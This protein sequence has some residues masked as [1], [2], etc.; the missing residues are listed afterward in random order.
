[1]RTL[2]AILSFS[3]LLFF[4]SLAVASTVVINELM[5]NPA[6]SDTNEW[7]EL[8]SQDTNLTSKDYWIDDDNTLVASGAVQT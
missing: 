6:G 4:P 8:Y 5:V 2:L 1:M 3:L 7:I